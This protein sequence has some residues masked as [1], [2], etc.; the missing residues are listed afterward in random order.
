MM[1]RRCYCLMERLMQPKKRMKMCPF[2]EGQVEIQVTICPFC[3]AEIAP[4]EEGG[5]S[6][7]K[8]A[9]ALSPQ[10]TL[11]SLYPPPYRSK[12]EEGLLQQPKENS[13]F[14]SGVSSR[15][16]VLFDETRKQGESLSP[17]SFFL[18]FFLSSLGI[19]LLF[20]SFFLFFFSSDG[21]VELHWKGYW[22]VI[23]FMIGLPL[24][25]FGYK[26]FSEEQTPPSQ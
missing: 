24:C 1:Q 2:C 5:S 7:N 16:E 4:A 10:E 13:P 26:K 20:L 18:P 19:N 15:E 14:I 21:E 22:W 23:Y 8:D 9:R 17:Q 25:I 6:A 11:A 12:A 3:G